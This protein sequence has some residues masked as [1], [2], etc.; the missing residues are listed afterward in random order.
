MTTARHFIGD[1]S[2]HPWHFFLLSLVLHVAVLWP[3]HVK[4]GP[5]MSGQ[6]E[7]VLSVTLS[8]SGE[9]QHQA[10]GVAAGEQRRARSTQVPP[11]TPSAIPPAV[12][13]ASSSMVGA[14]VAASEE[15]SASQV[16]AASDRSESSLARRRAEVQAMLLRDLRRYFEYPFLAQRLEWQG[17]V[18]LSVTVRADGMLDAV[19]L[20]QSSG[21]TLLDRSAIK[22]A[23]RVGQVTDA[24]EWLQGEALELPLPIVYQLTD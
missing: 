6:E 5:R 18:W 15:S 12:S 13:T 2:V 9:R 1:F 23:R 17:I 21:H 14:V 4:P 19:H 16:K 11:S 3:L 22:A 20:A 24:G 8:F 7:T 10:S